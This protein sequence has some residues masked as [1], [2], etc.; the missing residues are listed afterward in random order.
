MREDDVEK[1]IEGIQTLEK[2]SGGNLTHWRYVL[3]NANS[4][5]KR[6]PY[7]VGDKVQLNKTPEISF[8]KSWGWMGGKHFLIEGAVAKVADRQF[9]DGQFVFGLMFDNETWISPT[10]G[11]LN[12]PYSKCIY[13][14]GE[15]WL[16]PAKL[17]SYQLTCEAL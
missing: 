17:D 4:L 15:S 5:W 16:V 8:E 11:K 13:S 1:I 14:F 12:L 2:L 6:C 7:K 3:N 10:D 9:Y